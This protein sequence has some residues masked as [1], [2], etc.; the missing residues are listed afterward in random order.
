MDEFKIG[1]AVK[2]Q[3]LLGIVWT[4]VLLGGGIALLSTGLFKMTEFGPVIYLALFVWLAYDIHK[5]VKAVKFRVQVSYDGIKVRDRHKA[6]TEIASAEIRPAAGM[7]PAIL[8]HAADRTDLVIPGGVNGRDY[9]AALVE[10]H[11]PNVTKK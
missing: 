4:V 7:K 11:V 10:K 3:A 6:W 8:L 1:A 2:T 5:F 9:L